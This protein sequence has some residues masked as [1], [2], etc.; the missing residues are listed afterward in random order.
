MAEQGAITNRTRLGRTGVCTWTCPEEAWNRV[1]SHV[2][3]R[4]RKTPS[5]LTGNHSFEA[6]K[7]TTRNSAMSRSFYVD[8][9]MMMG[10]MPDASPSQRFAPGTGG[11]I[12]REVSSS[13]GSRRDQPW[14]LHPRRPSFAQTYSR[15]HVDIQ[16]AL[17]GKTRPAINKYTNK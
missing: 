6:P 9:L 14:N 3:P 15:A 13:H 11:E 1:L 4:M 5:M 2:V 10:K 12:G 17:P 16:P 7:L 8:S